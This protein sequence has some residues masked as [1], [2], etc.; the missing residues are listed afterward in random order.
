MNN[1]KQ[2]L[3]HKIKDRWISARDNFDRNFKQRD[4]N[5]VTL[6]MRKRGDY[7]GKFSSQRGIWQNG[8]DHLVMSFPV[9]PRALRSNTATS[10]ATDIKLVHEASTEHPVKRNAVEIVKA[11]YKYEENRLWTE[12]LEVAHADLA[13]L[14][15]FSAVKVCDDDEGEKIFLFVR[16][17]ALVLDAFKS[18]VE[19]MLVDLFL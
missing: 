7:A 2:G 16:A 8:L 14:G 15:G 5:Y 1:E 17:T 19:R 10:L 4:R 11:I 9:V 3:I 18:L 13:Q 12:S 6:E